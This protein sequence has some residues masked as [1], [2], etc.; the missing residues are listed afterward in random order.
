MHRIRIPGSIVFCLFIVFAV[1]SCTPRPTWAK[2]MLDKPVCLAPCWQNITP[3]I[4]TQDDLSLMLKQDQYAFNISKS[5]GSI[6]WGDTT[7]WCEDKLPCG[8]G[9]VSVL[10]AFGNTGVVQEIYLFP[11]ITLYLKDFI[12]IYG[13]PEKVVFPEPPSPDAGVVVFDVL[14][15]DVGLVLGFMTDNQGTFA[16]PAID[17]RKDLEVDRVIYTVPGLDY[18]FSHNVEVRS[19]DQFEWKGYTHYP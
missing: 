19:L 8:L 1:V 18:Y 12:P 17:L 3:G 14:Y 16:N 7:S 15:P 5:T 6:P 2:Q 13:Y 4:T 10:V 9:D 11:G